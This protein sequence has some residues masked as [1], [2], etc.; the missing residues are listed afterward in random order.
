MK[1]LGRR[2]GFRDGGS[3]AREPFAGD[4]PRVDPSGKA[5]IIQ[6]VTA[7]YLRCVLRLG[8]RSELRRQG[9]DRTPIYVGG[10]LC[11]CRRNVELW[12]FRSSV[13]AEDP[14]WPL[15]GGSRP[16]PDAQD[17]CRS[18]HAAK[19]PCST[20][21]VGSIGFRRRKKIEALPARPKQPSCSGQKLRRKPPFSRQLIVIEQALDFLLDGLLQ[22]PCA[23][24]SHESW[25]CSGVHRRAEP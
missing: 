25:L 18:L 17:A 3:S 13:C 16:T 20:M 1:A 5:L 15:A 10:Y 24:R 14:D 8:A 21:N 11:G 19:P 9:A 6:T 22:K 7:T 2:Q 4:L 12:E 23:K